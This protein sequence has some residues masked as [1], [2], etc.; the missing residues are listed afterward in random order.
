MVKVGAH[1]EEVNSITQKGVTLEEKSH[2]LLNSKQPQMEI[3]VSQ[4]N[5]H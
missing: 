3:P 1:K 4:A 5:K 2:L